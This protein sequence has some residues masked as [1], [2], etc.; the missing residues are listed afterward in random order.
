M[1][2]T[3]SII[4]SIAVMC[5]IVFAGQMSASSAIRPL[6]RGDVDNDGRINIRD[7]SM[8]QKGLAK[9]IDL[10]KRELFTADVNGDGETDIQD[11]T[12]I[13]K[14]TANIIKEFDA[15]DVFYHTVNFEN[16]SADFEDGKA[17]AGVPVTFTITANGGIEPFSY[18]FSIDGKVVQE[19]SEKNT[20][21]YTFDEVGD[22]RIEVKYFN[23]FDEYETHITTY[24]VVEP[25]TSDD[26]VITSI[27]TN[28][29]Y[30]SFADT[31]TK[32]T[33]YAIFGTA[34]YQFSF[35]LDNGALVQDFS[36][37]NEFL[38]KESL[39][40]GEHNVEVTVKDSNGKVTTEIYSLYCGEPII[41]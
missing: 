2:K 32:V 15:P 13:Q 6:Y 29:W 37:S 12:L 24:T 30:T 33:A 16:F 4:C 7:V 18:E 9:V 21:V 10:T 34:P 1:K 35:N 41:G 20:L 11:A 17:M 8:V 22:Y 36:E 14:R 23:I 25:Y 40:L 5:T 39:S 31:N 26:P 28:R 3:I 19:R 27:H 38:I